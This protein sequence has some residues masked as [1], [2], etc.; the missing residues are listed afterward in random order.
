MQRD[1]VHR[2]RHAVLAHAVMDVGA[3]VFARPDLDLP[4]AFVLFEGVRSAEPPS[5]S[6]IA[7]NR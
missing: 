5:N 7:A 2:R 6:G 3:V 4:F 1:A